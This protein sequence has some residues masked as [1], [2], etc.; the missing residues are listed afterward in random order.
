LCC[1]RARDL[2]RT[3]THAHIHRN[4]VRILGHFK[5][6]DFDAAVQVSTHSV[7]EE[8]NGDSDKEER[9][10]ERESEREREERKRERGKEIKY[11]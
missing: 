3:H 7:A 8:Y 6:I 4:I 10:K 2:R 11:G 1:V 5:L 9:N